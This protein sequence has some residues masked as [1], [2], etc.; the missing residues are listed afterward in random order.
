MYPREMMLGY[1]K[2]LTGEQIFSNF[3]EIHILEKIKSD[4]TR[5]LRLTPPPKMLK[6]RISYY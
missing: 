6:I 5:R 3:V 4:I 2:S 1:P